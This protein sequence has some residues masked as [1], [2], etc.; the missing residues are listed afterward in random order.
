MR[1]RAT[2][3]VIAIFAI[4]PALFAGLTYDFQSTTTGAGARTMNGSVRAEGSRVRLTMSKG[5]GILFKDGSVVVSV[6]GGRTLAVMDPS[7][8]SY[9]EI[10]FGELI[11]DASGLMKQFGA[12]V[13]IENPRVKVTDGGG[14][15]N[16]EGYPVKKS[17]L[18]SSYD[19]VVKVAGQRMPLK[20]NMTTEVLWTDR[21][22]SEFT[23]FLQMQGMR[24]GIE[25]LDKIIQAQT[26][27]IKGF[28]LQQK[29][30]TRIDMN[31][32][33]MTSTASS[34]VSKIQKAKIEA[35]DFA[36]PAWYTKSES[37]FEKMTKSWGN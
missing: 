28:P 33:T 25:A 31:G 13:E 10:N 30:T 2:L 7:A 22:G 5:D 11:G 8:K 12:A 15:G 21:L 35:S 19:M 32:N 27:N 20:I 3:F 17:T 9:Y 6:D 36:L 24:T 14:A 16:V 37:P 26:S 34:K 18:D 4:A 29:T 23:N 1:S